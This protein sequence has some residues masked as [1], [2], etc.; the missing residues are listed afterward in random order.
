[1]VFP[2]FLQM[3]S[4]LMCLWD[5]VNL[6]SLYSAICLLLRKTIPSPSIHPFPAYSFF[7]LAM[8]GLCC[9]AWTFSSCGEWGLL[10]SCSAW[11]SHC[12]GFSLQ[13][14]LLLWRTGSREQASVVVVHG[15][16]SCGIRLSP[17][18]ACR[19]F[20]GWRLNQHPLHC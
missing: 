13:W 14:L 3:Y 12:S 1:M 8:L 9:C 7:F 15:L 5:K 19:I 10:S 4:Q 2:H 20:P 16:S 18:A 11:A 17:P 6:G